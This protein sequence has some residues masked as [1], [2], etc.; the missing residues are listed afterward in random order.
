MKVS[1]PPGAEP[2]TVLRVHGKGLPVLGESARGDLY[3]VVRV[4]IPKRLSPE[5]TQLFEALRQLEKRSH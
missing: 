4:A 2:D 5:E 1:V 3:L